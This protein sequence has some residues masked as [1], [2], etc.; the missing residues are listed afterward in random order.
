[1]A[2]IIK[3]SEHKRRM[4]WGDE[5]FVD[6]IEDDGRRRRNYRLARFVIEERWGRKLNRSEWERIYFVNGN[7]L[8][9]SGTNA[10]VWGMIPPHTNVCETCGERKVRERSIDWYKTFQ[11]RRCYQTNRDPE[12]EAR[13]IAACRTP[14]ARANC[15]AAQRLRYQSQDERDKSA[16]MMR[17]RYQD[18]KVRRKMGEAI[19]RG[20]QDPGKRRKLSD[21]NRRRFQ[22][23]E[24]R[25][26]QSEATRRRYQSQA[27][28]DKTSASQRRYYQTRTKE[29]R[30]KRNAAIATGERRYHAAKRLREQQERERLMALPQ[31]AF[32]AV[33]LTLGR[34]ARNTQQPR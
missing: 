25:R 7:S 29:E 14:Q 3:G 27:E 17:R 20:F 33:R 31:A 5:R 16:A 11:C 4:R 9:V 10:R 18:P 30:D 12:A 26:R 1:M 23:P 15:S 8:D 2:T 13:R 19:R 32:E 24:E 6:V 22:N 21:R 28:R 34:S